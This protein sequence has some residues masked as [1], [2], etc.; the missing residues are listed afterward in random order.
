[1]C[2]LPTSITQL[3]CQVYRLT[4]QACVYLVYG[5]MNF[6]ESGFIVL[7]GQIEEEKALVIYHHFYI[8]AVPFHGAGRY[9]ET[10]QL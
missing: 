8:Q 6:T 1:M 5:N 3:A 4:Y 10:R 7:Y 2:Q 9:S